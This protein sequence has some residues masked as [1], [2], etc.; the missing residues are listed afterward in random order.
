MFTSAFTTFNNRFYSLG[1]HSTVFET[2]LGD[3]HSSKHKVAIL[4]KYIVPYLLNLGFSEE[5]SILLDYYRIMNSEKGN[6]IKEH[7]PVSI[8]TK[9][10]K[11]DFVSG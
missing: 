2:L 7:L 4:S 10:K 11:I 5:I 9:K 1:V 6:K 8:Y 3:K